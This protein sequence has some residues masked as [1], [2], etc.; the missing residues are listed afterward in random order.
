[1]RAGR[2]SKHGVGGVVLFVLCI[3]RARSFLLFA[4]ALLDTPVPSID[5]ST[6]SERTLNRNLTNTKLYEKK[7]FPYILNNPQ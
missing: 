6:R 7:F 3:E 4:L 2:A 1:M 5:L